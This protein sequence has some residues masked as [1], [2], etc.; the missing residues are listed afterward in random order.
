[1]KN[2]Y[3]LLVWFVVT[4]FVVYA[5]S[6][7]TA[8]AVFSGAIKE[9]LNVNDVGVSIA[10]GA[11]I[12]GFACM[13]IPAGYLL[14]KYNVRYIVSLGILLLA[15]GNFI[16]SYSDS[17]V[18]FSFSNFLQGVGASFSFI[19]AGV[20]IGQ[21]F[22]PNIF[23]ILFGLTQAFSCVIA[24]V[25]HYFLTLV[26]KNHP[27]NEIYQVFSAFGGILCILSFLIIKSPS[28]FLREAGMSLGHSL[29]FLLK[30][31]QIW[32]CS[33]AAA[34]SFGVLLAYASFWYMPVQSYF[35][36]DRFE[37]MITSGIIFFG[38]G[39]GTPFWGWVSN[40]MH[41]R[42]TIIHITVV[43]G[44]M[45]LLAGLYMPHFAEGS[46]IIA[47]IISFFIGFFLCG[48]ML[49]YTIVNEITPQSTRGVALSITN[50]VVFI[51]NTLLMF[52][53]YLLITPNS[54]SFFTY[55]WILPFFIML[56]ILMFYFVND[57][58]PN[59]ERRP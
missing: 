28:D 3:G 51:F 35:G 18:I 50:T 44:V 27:W 2:L 17:L 30:Q 57:T 20:L 14:D 15:I 23:P 39:I 11:F 58:N 31:P 33:F 34:T 59:Y 9:S 26:L 32:L 5:F 25:I 36:V 43:L 37:T 48:S 12:L 55:L 45:F 13:Q 46:L 52:I 56:S 54:K 4:L 22:A 6:L 38:I 53:P 7:N 41:S 16:I 19:A 24:G 8:A 42:K 29:N 1:M 49:Y 21:W 47:K 10:T 40:K